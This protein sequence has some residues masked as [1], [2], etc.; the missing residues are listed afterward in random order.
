MGRS[1]APIFKRENHADGAIQNRKND[2]IENPSTSLDAKFRL[3]F[4]GCHGIIC[5]R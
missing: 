1:W 4:V 2:Q 3:V 5:D